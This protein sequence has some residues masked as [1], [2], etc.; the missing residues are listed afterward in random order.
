MNTVRG[1][2][3]RSLGP[4]DESGIVIGGN[5]ELIFNVEYLFPW[6]KRPGSEGSYFMTQGTPL[7]IMRFMILRA[8]GQAQGTES[9]GIPHRPSQA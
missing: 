7:G 6:P 2:D 5:K 4:K 9:G 8:F 3:P 1:F